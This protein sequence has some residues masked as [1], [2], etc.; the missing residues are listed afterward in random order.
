ML[1]AL[2]R[3]LGLSRP[4]RTQRMSGE[5]SRAL[6]QRGFEA[7]LRARNETAETTPEKR[8]LWQVAGYPPPRAAPPAPRPP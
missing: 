2:G 1:G 4:N 3:L 7:G 5:Q 8:P 6:L